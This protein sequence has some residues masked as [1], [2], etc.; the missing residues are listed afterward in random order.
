MIALEIKNFKVHHLKN[1]LIVFIPKDKL[2]VAYE[3]STVLN[4]AH[5]TT[6]TWEPDRNFDELLNNT[7]QGKI[8]EDMFESY[9]KAKDEGIEYS[10][11]DIFRTDN[12][13]IHAPID[14]ILYQKVM[15]M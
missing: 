9:V 7:L 6:N 10:S 4:I 15:Y 5:N 1:A 12:Y 3:D 14:G 8:V 13:R 2:R 11:Y